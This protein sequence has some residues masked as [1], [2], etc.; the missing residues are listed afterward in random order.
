M[1][2]QLEKPPNPLAV[3]LRENNWNLEHFRSILKEFHRYDVS[4][5]TLS[6]WSNG[7]HV[8][9]RA[10]RIILEQ[11]TGRKITVESWEAYALAIGKSTVERNA[12][13]K[14]KMAEAREKEAQRLVKKK[15]EEDK[16]WQTAIDEAIAKDK[17]G[18]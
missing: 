6:Y 1:A 9:G 5:P 18:A 10:E 11:A 3:Y 17:R 8:P 7:A 2:R 4:R 14:V 12:R 13:L 16:A 15:E